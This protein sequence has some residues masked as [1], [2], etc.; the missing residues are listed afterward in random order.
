[1]IGAMLLIGALLFMVVILPGA[2]LQHN[3]KLTE[4]DLKALE[5]VGIKVVPLTPRPAPPTFEQMHTRIYREAEANALSLGSQYRRANYE[6]TRREYEL[7]ELKKEAAILREAWDS[8]DA[9]SNYIARLETC[10]GEELGEYLV[11]H[12]EEIRRCAQLRLK[13]DERT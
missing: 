1:M 11:H 4:A 6:I 9:D 13:S 12:S 10:S 8:A 2:I 3:A 7:A 5:E